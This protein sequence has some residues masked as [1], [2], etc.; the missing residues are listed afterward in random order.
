MSVRDQ[1]MIISKFSESYIN[2][3]NA[4][5]LKEMCEYY[6]FILS[7]LADN[8]IYTTSFAT[9]VKIW[10]HNE[11]YG[12]IPPPTCFLEHMTDTIDTEIKIY[13]MELLSL[14]IFRCNMILQ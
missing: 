10:I 2:I 12:D 1:M 3:Y 9:S 7:Q 4:N 8:N 6:H 13:A 14:I 11:A 5:Q